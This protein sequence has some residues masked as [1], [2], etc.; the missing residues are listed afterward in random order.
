M[1]K[2]YTLL[3]ENFFEFAGERVCYIGINGP[4]KKSDEE[5]DKLIEEI[6]AAVEPKI[7]RRYETKVSIY[8]DHT[9]YES[10]KQGF[11]D[12]LHLFSLQK[13]R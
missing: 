3:E 11:I 9:M 13:E 2:P 4:M 10:Y 8:N 1:H 12:A 5:F 6:K 7:W